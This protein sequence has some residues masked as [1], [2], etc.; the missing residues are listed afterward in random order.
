VGEWGAPLARRY[1]AVRAGERRLGVLKRDKHVVVLARKLAIRA[2]P[3]D[4]RTLAKLAN[5]P[6]AIGRIDKRTVRL[7]VHRMI[8]WD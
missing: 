8:S 2:D 7:R 1:D 3:D 6:A 5:K 4:V